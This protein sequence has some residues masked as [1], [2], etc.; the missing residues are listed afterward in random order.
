[1]KLCSTSRGYMLT[2]I[3][4]LLL[5]VV[6][7]SQHNHLGSFYSIAHRI[8]TDKVTTHAY[9]VLYERAL[10]PFRNRPIVMLEVGLGCGMSY[11]PGKSWKVW[12]E[13]FLHKDAKISF[14]EVDAQC[15]EKWKSAITRG[16]VFVGSQDDPA[17]LQKLIDQHPTGID[18]IVDD[19]GHTMKQNQESF[20]ALWK[21]IRSGGIYA[22]ED[23]NSSFDNRYA[24][25]GYNS[26]VDWI[27]GALNSMAQ[28]PSDPVF[29]GLSHLDCA[30][31]ICIF[32]KEQ[33]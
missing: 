29:A 10:A 32:H 5:A 20:K 26:T 3:L 2:V 16:N 27:K 8:G 24:S 17:F 4:S 28:Q 18:I 7:Q 6:V 30:K 14:V 19:G 22:I 33:K 12:D 21:I 15:A 9:H 31:D 23:L 11:G 13:Y 25:Q 1:M